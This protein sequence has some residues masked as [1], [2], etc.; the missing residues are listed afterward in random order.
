MEGTIDACIQFKMSLI[1]AIITKAVAVAEEKTNQAKTLVV[2]HDA[3]RSE[4][5]PYYMG[6]RGK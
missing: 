3:Y 5:A 2:K 4:H 1:Q 6:E